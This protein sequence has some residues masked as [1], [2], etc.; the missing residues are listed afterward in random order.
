MESTQNKISIDVDD[1]EF[2]AIVHEF[3]TQP[4]DAFI[5][6]VEQMAQGDEDRIS[7]M[8]ATRL[9]YLSNLN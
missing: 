9:T 5:A 3:M 8:I 6:D 4:Y 1:D 2:R 7:E